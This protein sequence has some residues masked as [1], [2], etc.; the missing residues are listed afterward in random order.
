MEPIFVNPLKQKLADGETVLGMSVRL[1]R[2]PDIARIAKTTGHDF[3]FIDIQHSIF[4]V[5][6]LSHMA[7]TAIAIG[8]APVVRVRG[9]DDPDVSL[10]LDNGVTGIVYP[11]VNTADEARHAVDICK[12]APLGKRS[13]TGGYPMFDYAAI[14]LTQAIPALNEATLLVVMIETMEG[15]ENVEAIAAVPGVDVIHVGTNDL[16]VNMGKPGRFDDPEIVA[17]QERVNAA[18]AANG[19]IAGCGGNRDVARQAAA[20]AKGVR[21]LTTQTDIAFLS[22]AARDWTTRLRAE[23]G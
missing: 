1:A 23:I 10:L 14:P 16:L 8:I 17:A 20:V 9:I 22:A 13:V 11:D 18:C 12:F 4:N 5:E 19:K 21:F 3:L 6:T 2:S 15:L 7:Q